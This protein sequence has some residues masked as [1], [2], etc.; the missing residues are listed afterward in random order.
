MTTT[1]I[2]TSPTTTSSVDAFVRQLGFT[3][4]G[5]G[6]Y[7]RGE[8]TLE[9][10]ANWATFAIPQ[11]VGA[12]VDPLSGERLAGLWKYST[13]H[14][15][16][17]R[18]FDLPLNAIAT[19]DLWSV[20]GSELLGEALEWPIATADGAPGEWT[21]PTEA[22]ISVPD[23]DLIVRRGRFIRHGRLIRADDGLR[24]RMPLLD[25]LSDGLSE[26]RRRWLWATLIDAQNRWRLARII[27]RD[28]PQ[29]NVYAEIDLTGAPHELIHS[30]MRIGADVL[31]DLIAWL[32]DSVDLLSDETEPLAAPDICPVHEHLHQT[33]RKRT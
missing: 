22:E 14:R 16:V 9:I 5:V 26:S 19:Q 20:E 28:E 7:H 33:E 18:R 24:I 25:D 10:E 30:M 12:N 31:R 6:E 27:A 1:G 8:M 13:S 4:S 3:P 17:K 2:T 11:P 21:P 32:I 23:S 29:R 15:E